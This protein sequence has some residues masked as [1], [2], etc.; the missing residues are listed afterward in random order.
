[1]SALPGYQTQIQGIVTRRNAPAIVNIYFNLAVLVPLYPF[2]GLAAAI[3]AAIDDV[4]FLLDGI[5][6]DLQVTLG[7][8]IY[9][10]VSLT[11]SIVEVKSEVIV[12]VEGIVSD[13]VACGTNNNVPVT[14]PVVSIAV[15]K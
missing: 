14:P 12:T 4:T 5:I 11:E 9:T 13:S 6:Y 15:I 1:M 10:A 3:T 7:Q 8:I 2:G